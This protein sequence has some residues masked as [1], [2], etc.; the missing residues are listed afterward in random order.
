MGEIPDRML[1]R[2]KCNVPTCVNPEHLEVGT[3]QDNMNDKVRAGRQ[4]FPKGEKNG[5]AILTKEKVLDILSRKGQTLRELAD[6]FG[7]SQRQISNILRGES[8]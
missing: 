7:V 4:H 3:H 6:E 5:R 1:V 2:H 8:W